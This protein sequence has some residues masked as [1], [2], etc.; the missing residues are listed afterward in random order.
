MLGFAQAEV[1]F[2]GELLAGSSRNCLNSRKAT[3]T[4]PNNRPRDCSAAA[5]DL[6]SRA[7]L[8]PN[9]TEIN[10]A[11]ALSGGADSMAILRAL[12]HLK[13]QLGGAG[14]LM[15]LHV[16]HQL[17]G[18]ESTDDAQWC[19]QQCEA[20]AIPLEVL[21]C[22]TSK[23][24][25]ETGD[26]IEAAAR[27]GRYQLLA[28]AAELA[29]IRYLATAHTRDDQVETVLFRVLRGT[30]LRGLAGIPQTRALTPTVTLVR[31]LLD[32]SRAMVIDYLSDLGQAYRTDR[33]NAETRFTRNRL[34]HELLP[35]LR[36]QYNS[37][38]DGALVRLARQS[39]ESQ[40]IVEAQARALLNGAQCSAKPQAMGLC[41]QVFS[42]QSPLVV[43]EALRIAWREAELAEQ[44]MTYE[45]WCRLAA[46]VLQPRE[47]AVFNLPGKVR[48]SIAGERLLLEW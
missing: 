14:G 6:L 31:P 1:E 48:A 17:R 44:A 29:G 38:L 47:G 13:A 8:P 7:W 28:T 25:T 19:R 30:G 27:A 26:G 12:R 11:V 43:C 34:R 24:A 22:D 15:A 2:T 4:V 20:L 32:C 33:S 10:V 40:Q 18:T 35:L 36:E 45:W 23:Y 42:G 37:D 9:W 16:N 39:G 41:W 3:P 21:T 5:D 46:M